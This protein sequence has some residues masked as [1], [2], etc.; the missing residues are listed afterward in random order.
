MLYFDGTEWHLLK[1]GTYGQFLQTPGPTGVPAWADIPPITAVDRT[2]VSGSLSVTNPVII[3]VPGAASH[4]T[5]SLLEM[6]MALSDG[7]SS[8]SV[9][10]RVLLSA[11][12]AVLESTFSIDGLGTFFNPAVLPSFV[13]VGGDLKISVQIN[14]SVNPVTYRISALE[15]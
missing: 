11:A 10:F 9:Y 13:N 7:G 14:V 3:T 12:Q 8:Q 6:N 2:R 1:P 5:P 4:G 15:A